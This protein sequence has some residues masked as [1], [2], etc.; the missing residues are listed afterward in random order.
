MRAGRLRKL[1]DSC[2]TGYSQEDDCQLEGGQ[3]ED[4]SKSLD[5]PSVRAGVQRPNDRRA[6]GGKDARLDVSVIQLGRTESYPAPSD[7]IVAWEVTWARMAFDQLQSWMKRQQMRC[8]ILNQQA[9]QYWLWD[10]QVLKRIK[11]ALHAYCIFHAKSIT[12]K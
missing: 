7:L 3:S 8:R 4:L 6:P 5:K 9:S 1:A 2:G 12:L 10:L 11:K